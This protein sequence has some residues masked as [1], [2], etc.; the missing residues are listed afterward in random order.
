MSKDGERQDAERQE[1]IIHANYTVFVLG[2]VL[3][4]IFNAFLLL[5]PLSEGQKQIIRTF[6][7][8]ISVFLVLEFFYRW[9]GVPDKRRYFFQFYGWLTLLGSLPFPP[10]IRL[11]RLVASG[12]VIRKLRRGDYEHMGKFVVKHRAQSTLLVTI[13]ATIV[14][15]EIGTLLML[16]VEQYA[17]D[18]NIT[19]A[20]DSIWWGLVT[21][22]TVGYGDVYP[23]TTYGRMIGVVLIIAGVGIFTTTTSFL[24]RWFLRPRSQPDE[25]PEEAR[26]DPPSLAMQIQ[27]IR[28]ILDDLENSN[29]EIMDNV[30]D[31]LSELERDVLARMKNEEW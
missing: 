27:E 18:A 25:L 26:G 14:V 23:V 11:L 22:S 9:A 8:G 6:D 2:I 1:F 10:F 16:T 31:R 17:P 12:L 21:I 7:L 15:F 24:A 28:S 19:T 13:F 5:A 4:S 29:R 20:G 3:F 30:G